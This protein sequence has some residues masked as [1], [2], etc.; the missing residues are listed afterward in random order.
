MKA[1][2]S[3]L[4][5]SERRRALLLLASNSRAA[6]EDLLVLAHQFSCDM[7]AGLVLAGLATVVTETVRT[8]GPTIKVERYLITDDGRR[9]ARRLVELG[10]GTR[11]CGRR[12]IPA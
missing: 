10:P 2:Q 6:T 4:P 9:A 11:R 8:G 12:W 3:Q 5:R 1:L 7:L